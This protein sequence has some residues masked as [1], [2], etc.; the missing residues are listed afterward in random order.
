MA[1][2]PTLIVALGV[3]RFCGA[4]EGTPTLDL[5]VGKQMGRGALCAHSARCRFSDMVCG[6]TGDNSRS[7]VRGDGFQPNFNGPSFFSDLQA[8]PED[9]GL[10]PQPRKQMLC[11][12]AHQSVL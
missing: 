3:V 10:D 1:A 11:E 9:R 2:S 12:R 5:L 6:T 7:L 4:G 8:E